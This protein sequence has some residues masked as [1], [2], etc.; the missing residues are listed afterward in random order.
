[1]A[2]QAEEDV[3]REAGSSVSIP[4]KKEDNSAGE[5]TEGVEAGVRKTSPSPLPSVS[6]STSPH[7]STPRSMPPPPIPTSRSRSQTSTTSNSASTSPTATAIPA[8]ATTHDRHHYT[9]P[10]H[11]MAHQPGVTIGASNS[12]ITAGLGPQRHPQPLTP[13]ALHEQ[14]EKEQEAIVSVSPSLF[15]APSHFLCPTHYQNA[16]Q[17]QLQTQNHSSRNLKAMKTNEK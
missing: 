7:K 2:S 11:E 13:A 3:L 1:M 17:S 10:H 6:L 8:T 14:A 16:K 9:Y 15:S 4:D 12:N 5:G